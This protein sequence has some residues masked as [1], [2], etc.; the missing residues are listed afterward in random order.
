MF[1]GDDRVVMAF[2]NK[3]WKPGLPHRKNKR[4]N[5]FY[6]R[7]TRK[8][9]KKHKTREPGSPEVFEQLRKTGPP[10]KIITTAVISQ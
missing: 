4:Q 8:T 9:R 2:L 10:K 3:F 6:P 5:I 1:R 7:K